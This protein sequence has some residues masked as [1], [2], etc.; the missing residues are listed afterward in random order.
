MSEIATTSLFDQEPYERTFR[1]SIIEVKEDLIALDRTLFYPAGGGQPGDSGELRTKQGSMR[2]VET[3][4]DAVNRS[5]IWHRVDNSSETVGDAVDGA[6]DWEP[7]Y[8]NMRMHTCLHLLCSLISAPVTGCGMG[9]E[10]GRLD[11]DLPE[12]DLTKDEITRR[13]NE[14]ITSQIEVTTSLIAPQRRAELL[15]L[16]RN[17]Y[18]LPPETSDAIKV[19]HVNGVDVQPCGGTHVANTAEI[20]RVVCEKIEKKGR[21]NR[22]I[23][24]RFDN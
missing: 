14:L 22:R 12:M 4:R 3:F 19:I 2:V 21:Q 9:G 8:S 15:G 17:R 24:L 18:A 16:V 23:V 10:K 6:I 5:L 13:L 11:F 20:P 7:R 1:A